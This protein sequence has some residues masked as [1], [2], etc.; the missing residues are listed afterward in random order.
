MDEDAGTR[1]QTTLIWITVVLA[2]VASIAAILARFWH[3]RRSARLA[4]KKELIRPVAPER[5]QGLTEAEAEAR[6]QEGQ[7]NVIHF[8]PPRTRRDIWRGNAFTIFNLNLIGLAIAQLLLDLPLDAL[9]SLGVMCLNIGVNVIQEMLAR[10][11]LTEVEQSTRP[12]ATVIR[13][14]IVRSIDPTKIALGDAL[15]VGSGDHRLTKRAGDKVYAGSSCVAGHAAYEA[16]RVGDD[17]LIVSLVSDSQST[18]EELTSLERTID[19]VLR[20]L[21]AVVALFTVLLLTQYFRLDTGIDM[22]AVKSAASVIFSIAPSGLFF[23]I[24]LTYATGTSDLAKIGAL[25][26]RARSVESLAHTTAICFAKAGILTGTNVEIEPVEPPENREQL[27]GSRIRQILGDIARSTSVNNQATRAMAATFEGGRRA[28]YEEAPFMSVYGWSAISFD[29]DDLRGVYVMGHPQILEGYLDTGGGEP[30]EIEQEEPQPPAWRKMVAPLGRLFKRSEEK[31]TPGTSEFKTAL[32]QQP[33]EVLPKV[34]EGAE[35]IEGSEPSEDGA[36]PKQNIF[37]RLTGGLSRVFQKAEVDSDEQEVPEDSEQEGTILQF[38]YLPEL[39]T[40]H[41]AGPTPQLPDGLVPLCNL[42]Y[43]EVVRP[44]TIDTIKAFSESGVSIKIFS[45]DDPEQAVTLLKQAGMGT[46]DEA[47]LRSISGP[48]LANMSVEQIA[49]AALENTVFGNLAPEQAGQVVGA[50]RDQGQS[51][52]VIGDSVSDLPAMRQANLSVSS[53]SSS[54]SALGVA[55]M[56]LLEDSPKV[57]LSV[58]EKGQ[59]IVNGLLSVLKLYLTQVSYL[60]LLIVAVWV[61]AAGF[62]YRAEQGTAISTITLTI[63]A[64]GLSL[65]AAAG[66]LRVTHFGRLLA[67]FVVPAAI[68]MSAAA[69]IVYLLFLDRSGDPAYAQLAIT[70]TLTI[71]GLL[72]VI[73]VRPP[74]RGGVGGEALSGDWRPTLLA[75][76]LLAI[77]FVLP[78]IPLA[79]KYLLLDW[80]RQPADYL[81]VGLAVLTWAF[82]VRFIWWIIPPERSR[83]P[84]MPAA[85]SGGAGVRPRESF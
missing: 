25:V 49:H 53:Q 10:R 19:R 58:L 34:R 43:T 24:F 51:V 56:V 63:P 54:Q 4:R 57:L 9:L 68:T 41:S 2:A 66:V 14:G 45:P 71:A 79:Q 40:L 84:R 5:V 72:L 26:H 47:P 6:R 20:V 82:T 81:V 36:A 32:P 8:T 18:K 22:D 1:K 42:R 83:S 16:Q 33:K 64:V 35:G 17:R 39:T 27:A 62:P 52:A 70:Y 3:K 65:W 73:F 78:A 59:R 46:D 7:D 61:V 12:Q 74:W 48:Q 69:L 30:T 50:L 23:M 76:S 28:V 11:R 60:A 29:D 80:L 77:F 21:L 37:K 44:E 55:D 75:L 85:D 31:E 15:V 67:R 13:E 38:A